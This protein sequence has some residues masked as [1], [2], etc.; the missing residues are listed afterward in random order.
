MSGKQDSD[1]LTQTSAPLLI[2]SAWRGAVTG[3]TIMK[4]IVLQR[5]VV[6]CNPDGLHIRPAA[7]LAEA[8][9]RFQSQVSLLYGERRVDGRRVLDV[10]TLGVEPGHE[11]V[12]E[13]NGPDAEEALDVLAAILASATPPL[14]GEPHSDPKAE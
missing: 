14:P 12:L 1:N 13:V 7:A 2:S 11:I 9:R 6:I 5:T 4:E 8:S 10:I 3:P